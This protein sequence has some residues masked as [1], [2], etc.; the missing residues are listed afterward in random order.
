MPQQ[1]VV[2]LHTP[3]ITPQGNQEERRAETMRLKGKIFSK[4]VSGIYVEV[5]A[6]AG[7]KGWVDG[8]PYG[9]KIFIPFHKIDYLS[10]E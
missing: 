2:R 5:Q 7:V 9:K 6:V 8:S 3:L 1:V 4:E 10:F